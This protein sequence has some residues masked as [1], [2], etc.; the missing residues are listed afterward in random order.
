MSQPRILIAEDEVHL[1]EILRFQL[2]AAGFVVI[3]TCNG[4]EAVEAAMDD[5][6]DLALLDVMM[7]EMDGFEACRK[8]RASFRTRHV[9]IVMLTAKNESSDKVS[10]LDGGANDYLTKPWDQQELVA[11]MNSVLQWS[12][13]QR[14]ASPL[15]GLPGNLSINDEIRRRIESGEPFALIQAD[16][17]FFKSFNDK[18][19]YPRGDEAIGAVA[20]ILVETARDLGGEDTFV[21]HIGGDDFVILGRPETAE[22]I[23]EEVI[24]RFNENIPALYDAAD[25]KRGYIE[26]P[27]RRHRVE[28]FPL[29]SLTMALVSTDRIPVTHL[30]ELSDVVQELKAHGKS[31]QGSVLVGDRRGG[32]LVNEPMSRPDDPTQSAA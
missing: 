30:A 1:R 6:P 17:D 23:G 3:Q 31:I 22:E 14:S 32:P 2:E 26:V 4:R 9:P 25:R 5:P 11:R 15:T 20:Q 16:V 21:G 29:M 19:G 7:P 10:A 18:Y 12:K 24:R 8:M 28:R 13:L 27:N